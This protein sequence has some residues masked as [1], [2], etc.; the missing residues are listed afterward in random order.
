MNDRP[1]LIIPD[2]QIPMEA[3]HALKFCLYLKRHYQVPDEN[4][5][6]VGDEVD[7]FHGSLYP[8]EGNEELTAK[9]ELKAA[10]EKIKEWASY[11]PL[12]KIATSNHGM[13]WLKK[14]A[15]VQIPSVLMRTY[16]E[17]LGMPEGWQIRDSWTIQ[18]QK[19]FLLKHGL[20]CSGKTPY[21]GSAELSPISTV[22]GH[23]HSSAGIC[24][25]NTAEKSVFSMNVGCLI[26]VESF[27]FRY[28]KW[29]KFKPCLGAGIVANGGTMP[30]WVPYSY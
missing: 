20:D 24:Y 22:F 18:T 23:L 28:S 29:S 2:L 26:D 5:L 3:E 25:V 27:A 7:Q 6:C 30:I 21:R 9:G 8:K 10:K 4:V 14:A 13:R 17:V 19:P 1:F 11:L 15:A 12:M 16:H